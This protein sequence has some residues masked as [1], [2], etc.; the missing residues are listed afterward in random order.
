MK[1]VSII[2]PAFNS[3]KSIIRAIDSCVS[4][5]YPHCEVIVIN[6]GSTDNTDVLVK[7]KYINNNQVILVNK[8]NEGSGKARNIGLSL[9]SGD[10]IYFLDADDYLDENAIQV[11]VEAIESEHT[12]IAISGYKKIFA[13]K[14]AIEVRPS[15]YNDKT[16]LEN[17]IIDR[18]ISSPWAKL[19]KRNIIIE[20][21]IEFSTHKIMQDSFF[22]IQYFSMIRS[23]AVVDMP[24]YNYDKSLS[25]A[26]V[27]VNAE[28]LDIIFS[29]L[30][31]QKK[32][33]INV[34]VNQNEL[35]HILE[36]FDVRILRLGIWFPLQLGC[37]D[38]Q[39]KTKNRELMKKGILFNPCLRLHERFKII[40]LFMGYGS[41]SLSVKLIESFKKW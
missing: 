32:F 1:K 37:R 31:E 40:A 38:N 2:I 17:F 23:V 10:Y 25:T 30:N 20:N 4:Q 15:I 21:N 29:S 26:T 7:F 19:F 41:Y 14:K 9:A 13:D 39:L 27:G 28:K 36:L 8:E 34:I 12:D 5:S 3:K 18:I 11:M 16:P 6:D 24:L 33:L 22:N 35:N